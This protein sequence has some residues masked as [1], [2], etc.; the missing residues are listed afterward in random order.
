MRAAPKP[1]IG[2]MA[3]ALVTPGCRGREEPARTRET[4]ESP[5]DSLALAPKAGLEIW[6][7][8]GRSAR[9]PQGVACVER[10]LEIRGGDR[11]VPIP[12][13]YT[14][15]SPTLINDSTLRAVLWTNCHP[16]KPYRVDLR[17]GQPKPE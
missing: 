2:L 5:M 12:L 17:T 8:L 6:Y 4:T 15:E 11:R 7:T 10:G 14:G 16:V 1:I 3:V 9:S 13:L